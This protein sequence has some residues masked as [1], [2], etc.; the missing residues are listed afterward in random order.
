MTEAVAQVTRRYEGRVLIEFSHFALFD[1]FDYT[2]L[3]DISTR[4]DSDRVGQSGP[5]GAV[6]QADDRNLEVLATVELW[7][8]TP[9]PAGVLP[10]YSYSGTFICG[11]GKV[12]LTSVTGGPSSVV[13]ELDGP[14]EYYVEA[15]R[16]PET[17]DTLVGD[18]GRCERWWIRVWP[19]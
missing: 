15:A 12:L 7:T 14:G 5:G 9:P 1:F 8:A 6:F 13:V 10:T 2:S 19:R 18:E 4:S 11:S 16:L 3:S 17:L